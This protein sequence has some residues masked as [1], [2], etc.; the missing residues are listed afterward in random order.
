MELLLATSRDLNTIA[1]HYIARAVWI[2]GE[3]ELGEQTLFLVDQS[4][5]TFFTQCS[6]D[7]RRSSLFLIV[8]ILIHFTD[9]CGQS[10]KLSQIVRTVDFE[11]VHIGQCNFAVSGRKFTNFFLFNSEG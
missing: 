9:I 3:L 2:Y 7:F 11:W 6:R 5:Q 10:L 4:S 1:L 8:D